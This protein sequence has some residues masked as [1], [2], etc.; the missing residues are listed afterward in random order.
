MNNLITKGVAFIIILLFIGLAFAPNINANISKSSVD[1]EMVEITTEICGIKGVKPYTV[2][3]SKEDVEELDRLFD[4]IKKRLDKV[5]T[6][7]ETVETFNE[8]IVELDKYGLLGGLSVKQ[9]KQKVTVNFQNYKLLKFLETLYQKNKGTI[10]GNM[11]LLR[12][13]AGTTNGTNFN[14]Q[15]EMLCGRILFLLSLIGPIFFDIF[16]LYNFFILAYFLLDVFNSFNPVAVASR[17]NLGGEKGGGWHPP[18][19]VEFYAH[20][21]IVTAGLLGIQKAEGKIEGALPLPEYGTLFKGDI[22]V[23]SPGV[24]GFTGLH[25]YNLIQAKHFYLGS[26]LWVNFEE[27]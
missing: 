27:V 20:G 12:F 8:A 24:L 3:L 4:S 10:D 17:I 2:S 7:K 9:V 22:Y 14:S 19:F 13:I 11:N 21:W 5:V 18:E 6:R 16:H 23:F 25:I 1:S 15:L 26:A